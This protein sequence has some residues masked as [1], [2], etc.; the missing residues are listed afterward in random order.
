MSTPTIQLRDGTKLS[1]IGLGTWR[2]EKGEVGEAILS[3]IRA[4]YRHF[5]CAP[6]YGNEKEIGEAFAKAFSEGLVVRDNVWITSKLWCDSHERDQVVPALRKTL[7]DLQLDYLD[8][9]LVHWPIALRHGVGFPEKGD[10]FL[11][12]AEA[13]LGETWKGMEEA[14]D[15]GLARHIGVSNVNAAK[16]EELALGAIHPP[17]MNQV[18]CHPF[19][20]QSELLE[21]CQKLG[22]VVTAYCPLGSGKEKSGDTPDVFR[23]ETIARISEAH[24][25]SPAQIALAWAVQRGTVVIPKSTDAGRQEENLAAGNL[26]LK[27]EEMLEIDALDQGFRFIDGSIWTEGDSPYSLEWLWKDAGIR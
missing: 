22:V 26:D 24:G 16:L 17:E 11:T 13:P 4:G 5:D 25:V 12:A 3:A 10:D 14:R 7:Q 15:S 23:N 6:V 9:Y 8:L 1:A 19:L 2:S 21:T 18:E 20:N 27:P